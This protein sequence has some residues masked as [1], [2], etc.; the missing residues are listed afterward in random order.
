MIGPAAA[1]ATE[2]RFDAIGDEVEAA[3]GR[4]HRSGP[5]DYQVRGVLYLAD[6]ARLS[7][8]AA[9]SESVD[10][11]DL[12]NNA[13]AAIERG[14]TALA[15]VLPQVCARLG[16]STLVEFMRLLAPRTES[17]EGNAFGLKASPVRATSAGRLLPPCAPAPGHRRMV[18][19]ANTL[20]AHPVGAGKTAEMIVGAMELRRLGI[21]RP[22]FVVPVLLLGRA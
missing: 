22:C 15:G 18:Y 9:A 1:S 10:F 3:A 19:G 6:E 12:F 13:M 2:Q 4:R 17:V 7:T 5:E 16:K 21:R 20:L 11:G 14:N 8:I